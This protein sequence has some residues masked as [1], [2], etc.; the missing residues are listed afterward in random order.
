M[1]RKIIIASSI[2]LIFII[3]Y[4]LINEVGKKQS[5]LSPL[6]NKISSETKYKIKK[7]FLPYKTINDYEKS[8]REINNSPL[9]KELMVKKKREKIIFRGNRQIK[10]FNKEMELKLFNNVNQ[11]FAGIN[12]KTPGSAYLDFFQNNLIIVSSAGIIGHSE[13]F[14]EDN[15]SFNQIENN[16]ENI[17]NFKSFL[18]IKKMIEAFSVKDLLIFNNKIYISYTNQISEKCWNT[19]IV[20]AEMNFKKLEFKKLFEPK[21]CIPEESE[22]NEFNAH[23]SG[24]RMVPYDNQHILFTIGEYRLRKKAQNKESIFGKILKINLNDKNYKILSMGHRNPQGLTY[25]KIN[26]IILSTEHGPRGGDE[27]NLIKTKIDKI[28]NF[29]WP[30]SSYGEHYGDEKISKHKYKLYPLKKSH[31]NFGFIEPLKYFV[32]SIGISEIITY[33]KNKYIVSSLKEK[34]LYLLYLNEKLEINEI[35]EIKIGERIRDMI[36]IKQLDKIILFLEDSATIGIIQNY[37]N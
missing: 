23:Q 5:V 30:V 18:N 16:L 29:G 34:N 27:I 20:F 26:N 25:D 15:I 17:V 14:N 19:S 1:K 33:D 3:L 10:I 24:G 4:L 9:K 7:I 6:K 11:I 2:F 32:P 8:I 12:R 37:E 21:E 13:N 36:Y 28:Q 35:K 22:L 31:K